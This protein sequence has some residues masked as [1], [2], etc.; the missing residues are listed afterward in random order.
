MTERYL[1]AIRRR[2]CARCIDTDEKGNCMLHFDEICAVEEH[3]PE[4]VKTIQR[5]SSDKVED[6]VTELRTNVCA[7]CKNQAEDGTCL[8]R[9]NIDCGLDRYFPLI[10]QA[11]EEVDAARKSA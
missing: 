10:I 9:N 2:V 6:Y 1:Q 8:V 4:I 11:V 3:L 5:V 7:Q